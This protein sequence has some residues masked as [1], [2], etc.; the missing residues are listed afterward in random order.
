MSEF[1]PQIDISHYTHMLP[2]SEPLTVTIL[3]IKTSLNWLAGSIYPHILMTHVDTISLLELH[4][5]RYTMHYH[6]NRKAEKISHQ[7]RQASPS[8]GCSKD[9]LWPTFFSSRRISDTNLQ[10]IRLTERCHSSPLLSRSRR[11]ADCP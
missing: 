11:C 10:S 5:S 9:R 6:L 7:R 1:I 2:F 4:G 3:L 8:S